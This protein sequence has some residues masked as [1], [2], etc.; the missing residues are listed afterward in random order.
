MHIEIHYAF[1]DIHTMYKT[2]H[3]MPDVSF[4]N[5][6]L[7]EQNRIQQNAIE[8][9]R[10]YVMHC[11]IILVRCIEILYSKGNSF[12][13]PDRNIEQQK[14][15]SPD[16]NQRNWAHSRKPLKSSSSPTLRIGG[17]KEVRSTFVLQDFLNPFFDTQR[18]RQI[19]RYRYTDI[20]IYREREIQ[21]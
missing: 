20:Y 15:L 2:L 18:D 11:M 16:L 4:V 21:A 3:C 10:L 8:Q 19:D 7:T 12:P 1:K 9:N 14:T 5:C 17:N 13:L 6:S